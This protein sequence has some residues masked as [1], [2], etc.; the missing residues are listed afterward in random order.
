MQ[1]WLKFEPRETGCRRCGRPFQDAD[2]HVWACRERTRRFDFD[3][4]RG[5]GAHPAGLI[6]YEEVSRAYPVCGPCHRALERG[7]S[8]GGAALARLLLLLAGF[9]ALVVAGGPVVHRWA[10][11]WVHAFY[12]DGSMG[13]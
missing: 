1:P 6:R 7:A 13:R 10:P 5:E 11:S 3:G 9:A 8:M 4:P 2:V 12:R